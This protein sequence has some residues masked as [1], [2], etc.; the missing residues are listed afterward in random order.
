MTS[1]RLVRALVSLCLIT[2]IVVQPIADVTA[3]A[4]CGTS[5]TGRNAGG[6]HAEVC[7]QCGHCEVE[8]GELCGCCCGDAKDRKGGCC[9]KKSDTSEIATNVQHQTHSLLSEISSV[10]PEPSPAKS[11]QSVEKRA[12]LTKC[13]CGFRSEPIAPGPARVPVAETRDLV[14]IAFLDATLPPQQ[15]RLRLTDAAS[16]RSFRG[17][18]PRYSQRSLCIWRL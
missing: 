17:P 11:K 7:H 14:V 12:V 2:V 3:K 6:M 18:S 1:S 4:S 16:S 15:A 5:D 13:L 10:V 9:A 8:T